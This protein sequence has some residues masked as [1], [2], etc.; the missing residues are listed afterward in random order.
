M[1][2]RVLLFF[3][4]LL[5]SS[6][7]SFTSSSSS[8]SPHHL[9]HVFLIIII[10]IIVSPKTQRI[11]ER[12]RETI[13]ER[14]ERKKNNETC[15]SSCAYSSTSIR[16][17]FSRKAALIRECNNKSER[18]HQRYTK[19]VKICEKKKTRTSDENAYYYNNKA[20]VCCRERSERI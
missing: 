20:F 6:L 11:R 10:I 4:R 1:R 12:E 19:T 2:T 8:S 5:S 16:V 14:F 17:S 7:T 9:L 18:F 3:P 15:D 13:S